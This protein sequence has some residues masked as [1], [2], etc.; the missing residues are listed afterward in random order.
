M[1][2]SSIDRGLF[3]S[4]FYRTYKEDIKTQG[5]ST[6]E[7]IEI[8]NRKTCTNMKLANY[9]KLGVDG[10]VEPGSI[11]V[12]GDVII[13][14]TVASMENTDDKRDASIITRHN[15]DGVVDKTMLTTNDAIYRSCNSMYF[16]PSRM[17]NELSILCNWASRTYSKLKCW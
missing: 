9:D 6:K 13:G 11:I 1:N 16:I 12:G 15:E 7:T 2:Q 17:W 3:R 14:K 4:I 8:P 10:I 5:G